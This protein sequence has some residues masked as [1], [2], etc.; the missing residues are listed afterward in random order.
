MYQNDALKVLTGEVRLSYA[1]L[2]EPYANPQQ[3]GAKAKYSVTL[4]IPKTDTA[5]YNDIMN[6][7]NAAA[8]D[9][10]NKV[11]NGVKPPVPKFPLWD[12][13]GVRQSGLP[14]G[15]ECKG[16]WVMT[17]SSTQRPQVVDQSNINVELDPRD[18]YSGMY[19]RLTLR[20]FGYSNSGNK[21]VGCGLG[22]VMK[23]RDGEPLSGGASASADFAGIGQTVSA[24][25]P[26]QS[27]AN[28]GYQPTIPQVPATQMPVYNPAPQ[29]G[30]AAPVP[31]AYQPMPGPIPGAVPGSIPGYEQ[32][33]TA[34]QY[35]GT[36]LNGTNFGIQ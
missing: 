21:G 13:D 14:F 29:P 2:T 4:L 22:N 33:N 15:D 10:V 5:T 35:A 30:Y 17:A 32:Q 23:T 12:G 25:I 18:I 24:D 34:P 28:V 26:A 36:Q 3:Q 9:A 27:F 11:W 16:H 6:A 19:A 8:A 20:F 7:M 31:S 1:H